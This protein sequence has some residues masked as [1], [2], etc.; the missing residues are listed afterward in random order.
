MSAVSNLYNLGLI[1][2]F[3]LAPVCS[4]ESKPMRIVSINQCAD[5]LLLNLADLQQIKSVS[6]YVKN[7]NASWDAHLA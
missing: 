6:H 3:F 4:A 2:L 7:P 1:A 5:E